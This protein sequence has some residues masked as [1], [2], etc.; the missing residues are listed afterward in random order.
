RELRGP[1]EKDQL[2]GAARRMR[3]ARERA[4]SGERVDQARLADVG[5]A[6]NGDL[7]AAHARQRRGRSG[8][9]GELPIA[10]EQLAAGFHLGA[11][12]TG[13]GSQR[14]RLRAAHDLEP[15]TRGSI[16]FLNKLFRPFLA[17]FT[18]SHMST[19]VP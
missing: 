19:S 5:A 15:H 8:G 10:R 17:P 2:L 14:Q 12:A 1:G 18:W 11:G 9:G 16:F 13:G 7:D 6:G 3:G 4:P